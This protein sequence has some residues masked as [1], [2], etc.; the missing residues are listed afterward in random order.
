MGPSPRSSTARRR[1]S[2]APD[3]ARSPLGRS[4]ALVAAFACPLLGPLLGP[5]LAG[6]ESPLAA[7]DPRPSERSVPVIY[8]TD[9]FHPH[10]DPDDHFDLAALY[11]MPEIDIR[12]IVLD[13]GRR[14]LASPGRIPVSQIDRISGREV[15]T[16][17]GLEQPLASPSDTALDQDGRFQG[18][19]RFILKTLQESPVP[20]ALISVGSVRDIVAAY[21]REPDLL[22]R[23]VSAAL[24]FIG[25]ATHPT[26]REYNV[27]LDPH[28]YVGLMRSRIPVWWVPCFD[29]GVWKNGGRASFWQ[30]RHA[31]LLARASPQV[32]RYFAY[33]LGKEEGDPLGFLSRELDPAARERLLAGTRNLWCTAIFGVIA[34][35]S[36]VR[37]GDRYVSRAAASPRPV[38]GPPPPNDLFGFREAEVTVT[39]EAVVSEVAAGAGKVGGTPGS[40][41]L[42]RFEVRDRER[43][44]SGMTA[45]TADL[46]GSLGSLGRGG[47]GD[48]GRDL[49]QSQDE[50]L[51]QSQDQSLD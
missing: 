6:A 20:V 40:R 44:A 49:D 8:G 33:A 18:G 1:D 13:Q 41:R 22:A 36:I 17:L 14:Q 32:V 11:A 50:N 38:A 27:G 26:F 45:A 2:A 25:E 29:G 37:E 34:A 4:L 12:G 19:V 15:P 24:V 28:A 21:N 35:R 43:Y 42:L 16:F 39:D 48:A 10:E 5:L 9:L 3:R 47:S 30:A 23:K 51:D 46:L 31:D 7:A